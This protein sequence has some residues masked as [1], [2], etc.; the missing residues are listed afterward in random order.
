MQEGVIHTVEMFSEHTTTTTNVERLNINILGN[1][2]GI[3]DSNIG[4]PG[5]NG[6]EDRF[7]LYV[8]LIADIIHK[9]V[10]SLKDQLNEPIKTI[11][12]ILFVTHNSI[13]DI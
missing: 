1:N 3:F 13:E 7:D 6:D 2:V 4:T 10:F 9:H 12:I 11:H 8:D 5:T